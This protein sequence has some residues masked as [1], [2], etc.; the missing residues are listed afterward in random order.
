MGKTSDHLS[1]C[2]F[3]AAESAG[4]ALISLFSIFSIFYQKLAKNFICFR[5]RGPDGHPKSPT[6]GHFKIPH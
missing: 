3:S 2:S 1:D 5:I 6:C 4:R